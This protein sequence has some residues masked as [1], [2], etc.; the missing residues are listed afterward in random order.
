MSVYPL[1]LTP[2]DTPPCPVT[3]SL[4]VQLEPVELPD[5]VEPMRATK[6]DLI[7]STLPRI[8][9]Q[10]L[11]KLTE[12][13]SRGFLVIRWIQDVKKMRLMPFQIEFLVRALEIH[14][15]GSYRFKIIVL[16][17]GRQNGKTD[18]IRSL[19]EWKMLFDG[20]CGQQIINTSTTF[21]Y[22]RRA[23]KEG[24]KDAEGVLKGLFKKP[25]EANGSESLETLG[26]SEWTCAAT[27]K[28]AGRSLAI[29]TVFC[30]EILSHE[31]WECWGALEATTTAVENSQIYAA[32]TGAV[33][34]SVVLKSLRE[35]AMDAIENPTADNDSILLL[36]WSAAEGR[37]IDDRE[38]WQESNPALGYRITEKTLISAMGSS[39][40][41]TFRVERLCQ[42]V[43]SLR[44]AISESSWDACLDKQTDL[45]TM[46]RPIALV[47]D[48]SLDGQH[49]SAVMA[50][51]TPEGVTRVELVG[52]WSG[53]QALSEAVAGVA[54]LLMN[55]PNIQAKGYFASGP[56]AAIETDLLAMGFEPIDHVTAVCQELV[57]QV[58][59]R[60]VVHAGQETLSAHILSAEKK[61]VGDGFR[62]DRPEGENVSYV[63]GAYATAGALKLSRTLKPAV[64]IPAPKFI[65][66]AQR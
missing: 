9:T 36:E 22:A 57:S 27:N 42:S 52:V 5:W 39:D 34:K 24:A 19:L 43:T 25:R 49:V 51:T 11:R 53:T 18:V 31:D 47:V 64:V 10:P 63:D 62:F 6:G 32:S 14:E 8:G 30:D 37:D 35:L 29:G 40:N 44:A 12:E 2:E 50:A 26:G 1:D 13:T 65:K 21:K 56:G 61:K 58:A 66:A 55:V 17:M 60:K 3:P 41:A 33:S 28:D 38:G 7:G 48:P 59:S 46:G 15:D 20:E 16:L 23:W 54:E 45:K 4:P